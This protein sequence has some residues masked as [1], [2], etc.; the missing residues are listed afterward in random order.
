MMKNKELTENLKELVSTQRS[1]I[2]TLLQI[3]KHLQ[4]EL[5]LCLYEK[6]D[7]ED[8]NQII[9]EL[10]FWIDQLVEYEK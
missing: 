5:K 6:I 10:I 9:K 1:H 8:K 4:R 3:I 7:E 2:V